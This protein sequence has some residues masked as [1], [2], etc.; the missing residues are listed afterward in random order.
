MNL[1][2]Y[3]NPVPFS[4]TPK[5]G[6]V[7]NQWTFLS[8]ELS[9]T[10]KLKQYP[11]ALFSVNTQKN[12]N[13]TSEIRKLLY[14]L[15]SHTPKPY[16]AIDLGEIK[17]G[18]SFSDTLFAVR[19]VVEY[20][21]ENKTIPI[22]ISDNS[23]IPYSIYL[24][25][26]AQKKFVNMA[27]SDFSVKIKK[28]NNHYL[29]QILSRKE[30]TLFNYILLG[31]QNYFTLPSEL[32]MMQSLYFEGLRLGELQKDITMAEPYLRDSDIFCL[33]DTAIINT[34]LPEYE[35]ISPNGLSIKECCQL[36]MYAGFSDRLSA[37]SILYNQETS[38][39][40]LA[41]AQ[42][43]WHFIDGYTARKHDYPASPVSKLKRIHVE[44]SQKT[45]ITFYKS[46][47]SSRWWM[48]IPIPKSDFQKKWLISCSE[49]DYTQ[50]C[51]GNIPDKWLHAY[52][53]LL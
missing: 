47:K 50:A 18:T 38:I 5:K 31:H 11:L 42:I 1:I 53:K 51:N 17:N 16:K 33:H 46:T 2:D 40:A 7:S 10:L 35:N 23:Y 48:E 36:A 34:Y 41:M 29:P 24:A 30:N 14:R 4:I 28:S 9:H 3:F 39:N 44:V 20:L 21:T 19:D 13:Y 25:Y 37:F 15:T 27:V 45:Y 8:E 32:S 52:Q 12:S 43:I 26:E 49:A 22:I 6:Y